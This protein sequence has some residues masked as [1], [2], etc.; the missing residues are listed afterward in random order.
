MAEKTS[1][2]V[3]GSTDQLFFPT[4]CIGLPGAVI[5]YVGDFLAFAFP[6]HQFMFQLISIMGATMLV[7][8]IIN[9][10]RLLLKEESSRS[11]NK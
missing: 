2:Q 11:V 9:I 1:C 5:F 8:G 6:G 7:F 10:I 4:F 3:C